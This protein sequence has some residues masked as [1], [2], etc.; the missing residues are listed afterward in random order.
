[1]VR[2]LELASRV[3]PRSANLF[4]QRHRLLRNLSLH[5]CIWDERV[6]TRSFASHSDVAEL[7]KVFISPSQQ[8][9]PRSLSAAA[10]RRLLWTQS[11]RHG[12]MADL[13]ET[14]GESSV[15]ITSGRE[16]GKHETQ[17]VFGVMHCEC[18]ASCTRALKRCPPGPVR[19]RRAYAR[20]SAIARR[21]TQFL[22]HSPPLP[23]RRAWPG[24][25]LAASSPEHPRRDPS[26][27]AKSPSSPLRRP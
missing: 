18:T 25:P 26:P 22:P 14:D 9:R 11:A 7:E 27:S 10:Y 23:R 6:W 21:I 2:Q 5:S 24:L 16:E 20:L 12:W 15:S 1:M 3:C 4:E 17:S 19:E 8:V 13:E